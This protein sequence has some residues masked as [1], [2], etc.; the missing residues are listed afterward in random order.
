MSASDWRGSSRL[1]SF[2]VSRM[3]MPTVSDGPLAVLG[4]VQ[5]ADDVLGLGLLRLEPEPEPA[6]IAPPGP[7]IQQ[8]LGLLVQ[9]GAAVERRPAELR[10]PL[11]QP[12][13]NPGDDLAV[14]RQV[15]GVAVAGVP[16]VQVAH[17]RDERRRELPVQGA[18]RIRGDRQRLHILGG[19]RVVVGEVLVMGEVTRPC[20]VVQGH[21]Q[22]RP[23]RVPADPA[24]RLQ[25]L[26]GVLGLAGDHHQ[27]QPR[28]VH[29]DLQHRGGEHHV[30]RARVR[31]WAAA[32]ARV[33]PAGPRSL[34]A[35][36]P[37]APRWSHGR[38][39][40]RPPAAAAPGR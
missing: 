17:G 11:P 36:S 6:R 35:S 18:A 39:R 24:G 9:V 12:L 34:P 38:G 4:L 32:G 20:P 22:P 19:G 15:V 16:L 29:P 10:G 26:G 31:A 2:S 5:Q 25:V 3:D 27:A 21:H 1:I 23:R 28:H 37:P 30:R 14:Q 7:L 33:S 8:R 40:T 13:P